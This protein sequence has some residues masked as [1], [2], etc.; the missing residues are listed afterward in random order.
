MADT[1]IVES[2][3]QAVQQPTKRVTD[4][5]LGIFGTSDNF[6]MAM[7]M[8]KA[9]ASSTIV[10]Q[11]FQKNEANCLIAIEQAQRLRVSPMM[12]MQNLHV[13]QGRP[14][15]SSKFLIAAINNSGKFDMELQFEETQ[16]KD[17]KPFSCT[18]WTTKN[19][20]KVNG[21]TV[22]M[23]MA[24]EEGWLSKNGSKWKTMP[25]LMLRYRAASFFSSPNCPELTMGLYT[26][27]EMQDDDFKE[28]PIENMKE[29][30]QQ[31]IAENANSQVFEE[32]NE[33]NKEANKD[34]LPPF[35]SA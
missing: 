16:D 8:A 30:V 21:M 25:Q 32:P 12:V 1:A 2:G 22:D 19:G 3:K 24:K 18:A 14:S 11:T 29:Q 4:Y 34:A 13:I 15:W 23:D 17:G 5:S 7:Q 6:I 20:R 27:E 31:E 35:M 9:L 10:P 33:Q 26:R 28:Y